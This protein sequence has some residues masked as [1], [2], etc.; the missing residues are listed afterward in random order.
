MSIFSELILPKLNEISNNITK[1]FND[2]LKVKQCFEKRV[3]T[4]RISFRLISLILTCFC[5]LNWCISVLFSVDYNDS[6]WNC[7]LQAAFEC[8]DKF[9]E[10]YLNGRGRAREKAPKDKNLTTL[11]SINEDEG[12]LLISFINQYNV[13]L[14][15]NI[16]L[17][18]LGSLSVP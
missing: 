12:K 2:D 14:I 8:L 10:E 11:Q 7:V 6:M 16:T 18:N 9:E 15:L 17:H 3:W 1:N 5:V 4:Q 13:I